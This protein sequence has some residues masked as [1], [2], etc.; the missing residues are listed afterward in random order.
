LITQEVPLSD[1]L[2]NGLA[3]NSNKRNIPYLVESVGAMPYE[4]ALQSVEQF[5]RISALAALDC[6]F[7]YPQFFVLADVMIVCLEDTIYEFDGTSLTEKLTEITTGSTW[8]VVD[9]QSFLY[10]TNNAVAVTKKQGT[11][12]IDSSLPAGMCLCNFNGQVL[13]GAPNGIT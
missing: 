12:A 8:S 4:D 10:L 13:I 1:Y 9:F 2:K 7:P 3:P 6:S 11:Y 5:T